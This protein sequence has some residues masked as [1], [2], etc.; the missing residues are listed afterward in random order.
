[1]VLQ[2]YWSYR[3]CYRE[4]FLS[5]CYIKSHSFYFPKRMFI[6]THQIISHFKHYFALGVIF[7]FIGSLGRVA[8]HR[9]GWLK[10]KIVQLSG[11]ILKIKVALSVKLMLF[12]DCQMMHIFF[13]MDEGINS[14]VFAIDPVNDWIL[15]HV[16]F[17]NIMAI[18]RQME[19]RI[20]DYAL[21]LFRMISRVDILYSAHCH[22]L[23][24]K[25][26]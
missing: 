7:V 25:E 8:R 23:L 2:I 1:M 11:T 21:L 13:L 19:A 24:Q 14:K 16:A 22:R 12:K 5:D 9:F 4:R 26:A 3:G 17:C 20:R 15:F 6:W 10:I 18:L